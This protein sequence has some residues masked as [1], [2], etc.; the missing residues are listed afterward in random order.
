MDVKIKVLLSKSED[1]CKREAP[2]VWRKWSIQTRV[3]VRLR[4]IEFLNLSGNLQESCWGFP[5]EGIHLIGYNGGHSDEWSMYMSDVSCVRVMILSP[6]LLTIDQ[7][8]TRK[9]TSSYA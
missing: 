3:A 7:L 2:V 1:L 5:R 4:A 8:L 9:H 6:E